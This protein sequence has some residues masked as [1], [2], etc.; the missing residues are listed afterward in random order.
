M[1]TPEYAFEKEQANVVCG[2]EDLG[3]TY[4]VAMDNA[5]LDVDQLPQP[6]LACATTSSTN[7]ASCGTSSSARVTTPTP[8][9]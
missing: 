7:K 5:L 4:P 3:I 6:I 2:A 8:N 9:T 1:H